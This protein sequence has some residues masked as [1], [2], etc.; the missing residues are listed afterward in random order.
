M[1]LRKLTRGRVRVNPDSLRSVARLLSRDLEIV[2]FIERRIAADPRASGASRRANALADRKF[3]RS[4]ATVVVS[5]ER[6]AEMRIICEEFSAEERAALRGVAASVVYRLALER[7][8]LR[9][10]RRR[11]PASRSPRA[12]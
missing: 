9:E 4:A 2:R 11:S 6:A 10:L 3:H 7:A 12:R 1:T 8:E 5:D